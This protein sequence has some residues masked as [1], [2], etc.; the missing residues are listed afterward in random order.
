MLAFAIADRWE[1]GAARMTVG[2][3]L[4]Q[5][6]G[7][8]PAIA[9]RMS[10]PTSYAN[11]ACPGNGDLDAAPNRTDATGRGNPSI[12]R[13]SF[14]D[15]RKRPRHVGG[16][17]DASSK[18]SARDTADGWMDV[19]DRAQP[20][21]TSRQ[22][23]RNRRSPMRGRPARAPIVGLVQV[24]EASARPTP[25]A[26]HLGCPREPDPGRIRWRRSRHGGVRFTYAASALCRQRTPAL[27]R[28]RMR[29]R[30]HA[31]R[32]NCPHLRG[33]IRRLPAESARFATIAW[34]V[35]VLVIQRDSAGTGNAALRSR[36]WQRIGPHA[37]AFPALVAKAS[38]R[39][40]LMRPGVSSSHIN[41]DSS[42]PFAGGTH[43]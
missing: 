36:S 31:A 19:G 34:P 6:L 28:C 15:L 1:R 41:R 8:E 4:V 24:S 25:G 13:G 3:V 43:G 30:G 16:H 40:L 42:S 29:D 22:L 9:D 11:D 7:S 32:P 12:D 37:D 21:G 10:R 20:Q 2:D 35:K 18:S 14:V 27:M 38:S 23:P 33:T 17:S 5:P 26:V 39:H